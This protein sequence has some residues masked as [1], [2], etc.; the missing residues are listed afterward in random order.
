[1]DGGG[2]NAGFAED[3]DSDL[4]T[5]RLYSVPEKA[6]TGTTEWVQRMKSAKLKNRERLRVK[7]MQ[8][9]AASFLSLIS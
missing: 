5:V 2:A 6:E 8:K 4:S 9:V 1:M 7:N 3:G